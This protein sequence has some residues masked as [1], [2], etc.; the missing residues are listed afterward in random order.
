MSITRIL[1]Q[2]GAGT[3]LVFVSWC[4]LDYILVK[5]PNYPQNIAEGNGDYIFIAVVTLVLLVSNCLLY[6]RTG[7]R[8]V[9]GIF[10]SICTTI[11]SLP[12]AAVLIWFLGVRFHFSIGGSW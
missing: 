11:F 6:V 8:V 7:S 1:V 9:T 3:A 2:I 12:L 5:S 4:V 10:V